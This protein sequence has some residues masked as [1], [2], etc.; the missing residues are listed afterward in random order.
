MANRLLFELNSFELISLNSQRPARAPNQTSY[1]SVMFILIIF[2][3]L[4]VRAFFLGSIMNRRQYG[5]IGA[6]QTFS[7]S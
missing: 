4:P 7:F 3:A 2:L 5:W 1:D 6:E